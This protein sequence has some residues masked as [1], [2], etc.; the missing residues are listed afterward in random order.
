MYRYLGLVHTSAISKVTSVAQNHM[1]RK[2][3]LFAMVSVYI[4]VTEHR[5]LL[6][7]VPVLLRCNS[8]VILAP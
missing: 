5:A 8:S 7:K 6:E 3:T 1:T 2:I 4:S